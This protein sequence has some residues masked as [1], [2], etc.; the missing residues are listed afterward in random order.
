[1]LD[2]EYYTKEGKVV[3]SWV[4]DGYIYSSCD[5]SLDYIYNKR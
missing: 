3:D 5:F 1:M 2:R 4:K